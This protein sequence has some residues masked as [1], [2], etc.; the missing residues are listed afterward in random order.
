MSQDRRRGIVSVVLLAALALMLWSPAAGLAADPEGEWVGKVKGPD[1]KDVEIK[2]AMKNDGGTWKASLTDQTLGEVTLTDVKVSG[3]NISFKFQP[4]GVPYPAT[5]A[6]IYDPE[7]DRLSGTFAVRGSSRF[8][9]FKR[10]SGGD[11]EVK[12][13]E[14]KE[15]VRIRHDFRFGLNGR[16]SQWAALHVVK[17]E[18]YNMNA[19]T[20]STLNYD[21]AVKI[22]IQDGFCVYG[23][24]YHGGQDFTDDPAV[25]G[26]WPE[27]GIS[28]DSYLKLDG[29]E[30]GVMGFLGNKLSKTSAFNPYLTAAAG[31]V[32]WELNRGDRGSEVLV[33][34][35]H[36]LEGTDMAF[37]GGLGTEYEVN[38]KLQLELEIVWRFFKTEDDALWSDVDKDWSNTHVWGISFG[39]TYGLF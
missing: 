35:R 10:I 38:Q 34:E 18:T 30:I 15:P 33:L 13:E 25:I 29:W 16:V 6:G 37:S 32:S 9:K 4:E 19:S 23:R 27:L 2:L 31:Q 26:Q 1:N 39:A 8:V 11:M 5:F 14:P 36:P 22:F 28:S 17:D 24:Y 7:H 21:G 12:E 3:N 20:S